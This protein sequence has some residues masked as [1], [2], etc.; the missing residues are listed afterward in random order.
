LHESE[1]EGEDPD[2]SEDE[3]EAQPKPSED[4]L[5]GVHAQVAG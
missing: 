1:F 5:A 4:A 2:E 3:P